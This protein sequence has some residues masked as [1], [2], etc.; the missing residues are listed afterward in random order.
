[1]LGVS[2]RTLARRIA[3]AAKAAGLLGS[4][5]PGRN[6]SGSSRRWRFRCRR[7]SRRPMGFS[8]YARQVRTG[9]TRQPGGRRQL[10][11]GLSRFDDAPA[12]PIDRRSLGQLPRQPSAPRVPV[13]PESRAHVA[14]GLEP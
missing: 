13:R 12:A 10:L 1:M 3:A 2:G 4:L 11:R 9:R 6:G 7:A 8:G 14:T 5:G